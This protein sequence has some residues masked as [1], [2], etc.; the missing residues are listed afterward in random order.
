M[1]SVHSP[2]AS[3]EECKWTICLKALKHRGTGTEESAPSKV[4]TQ[5]ALP[6]PEIPVVDSNL[7]RLW[8]VV[9]VNDA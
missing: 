3:W 5:N 2:L 4:A 1:S 7:L 8:D 9:F 6:E